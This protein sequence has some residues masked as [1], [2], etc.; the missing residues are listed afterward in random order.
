[1]IFAPML[2]QVSLVVSVALRRGGAKGRQKLRGPLPGNGA[3]ES[4]GQ[5]R[6]G[7]RE[8]VRYQG[9]GSL[10]THASLP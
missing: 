5:V 4:E 3:F 1:M 7:E 8:K 9:H 10:P 2:W 6:L